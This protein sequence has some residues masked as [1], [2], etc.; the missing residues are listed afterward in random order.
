MFKLLHNK[1]IWIHILLALALIFLVLFLFVLS[2]NW[3]TKHG[4][5]STVPAVMGKKLS[6]AE[7]ILEK[8]GF[9]LVIQ[10]SVYYDSLPAGQILKQIP[11]ADE[12]VKINRTVYVTV[13]RFVAPD[14]EMPNLNGY[15][16]RNA[17]MVLR[18]SGLKIGDTTFRPDFA[19]NTILEA[20]Y[21]GSPIKPGTKIKQGSTIDLVLGLGVSNE[22]IPV[23]ELIGMTFGE[24][25]ALLDAQ[26]LILGA[27]VF[28]PDVTDKE[29][30]FVY[31]QRPA[32]KTDDG[33]RLS[34][35]PGQMVD[36]FLQVEKPV[37]DS[38]TIQPP[39]P[40]E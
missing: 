23:P 26:G 8:K 13:N 7:S 24:A 5:S 16:F 11:E 40:N 27:P 1:P 18:N 10:D 4:E 14:V 21:N 34:I 38:L 12:V 32:P 20:S 15:S 33:K 3:I 2:L 35:R 19:K 25:K 9:E 37:V 28:Q 17:E 36:I 30:A 22:F 39:T 29:N 31:Q 6:E